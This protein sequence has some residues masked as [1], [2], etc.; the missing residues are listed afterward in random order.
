[1]I[2]RLAFIL[3]MI[4][5]V[6]ACQNKEAPE[7]TQ[8]T[9]APSSVNYEEVTGNESAASPSQLQDEDAP[10]EYID[11]RIY[12]GDKLAI[13]KQMNARL[14]YLYEQDEEGYMSLFTP[15]APVSGMSEY[16]VRK[17]IA[18]S[19]ITITEQRK[20]YEATVNVTELRAGDENEYSS[21][22]VFQRKKTDGDAAQ[23]FIADID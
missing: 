23:W 13:V 10:P 21:M 1:M 20:I 12:A 15:R 2:Q 4:L 11:E 18:L 6:T 19:D 3:G 17:V 7:D 5:L 14:R 22:M 9:A 8:K 16:K